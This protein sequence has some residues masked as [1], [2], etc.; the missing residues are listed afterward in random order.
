M[1]DAIV[2]AG[3]LPGLIAEQPLRVLR[4]DVGP[5]RGSSESGGSC[6]LLRTSRLDPFR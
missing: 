2:D 3:R 1:V 4:S 5:D 6:P